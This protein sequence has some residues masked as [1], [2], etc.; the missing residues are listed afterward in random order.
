M[1]GICVF[2]VSA[3]LCGGVLYAQSDEEEQN[4]IIEIIVEDDADQAA[5][6]EADEERLAVEEA[7]DAMEEELIV[8][9][10]IEAME[11]E[12]VVE[13]LIEAMEEDL[14]AEEPA[15]DGADQVAVEEPAENDADQVAVEEPAEDGA[16]QVAAEEPAENDAD[17]VAAEEPVEGDADQVAVEEPVEGEADQV[18]ADKAVEETVDQPTAETAINEARTQLT[19]AKQVDSQ[20]WYPEELEQA[21]KY[22]ESAVTAYDASDW[23]TAYKAASQALSNLAQIAEPP[24]SEMPAA[25][26]QYVIRPWDEFGNCFWNIAKFFY[27]DPRQWPVI[28]RANKDKLPDSNNPNLVKVGTVID[29]PQIGSEIRSGVWDSG[30]SYGK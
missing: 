13:E 12:L 25:P 3:L 9:E 8:E 16:D 17:Q 15:E 27:G 7:I 1:R 30:K 6:D 24:A 28:Y 19:W 18:A 21:N 10:L 2:F 11:E 20:K 14:A 23:N 22:Y 4:L 26:A 5:V 29:L